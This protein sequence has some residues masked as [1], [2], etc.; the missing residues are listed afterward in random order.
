MRKAV[1]FL[2]F[3]IVITVL[4]FAQEDDGDIPV[5]DEWDIYMSDIYASGDQIF[6]ISLG[7]V[8]P[9]FFLNDGNLIKH[10][11][12]P[13]VGGTGSLSYNYFL[14]ANL[15]L[16]GEVGGMFFSTLANHMLYIIPL[17]LRTGYQFY[18]WRFEFPVNLTI[19]MVWHNYISNQ[20]YGLYIKGGGSGFYRYN[21]DWSF[22]L[23]LNWYWFPQWTSKGREIEHGI[24][25]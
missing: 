19:G 8:F 17:G 4:T 5:F 20:Y 3:L 9:T 25:V 15:F 14:N 10:N 7:T 23:N 11:I 1:A 13:P 12:T 21:P 6:I 2:I 18:F 24:P 16:G 22:G